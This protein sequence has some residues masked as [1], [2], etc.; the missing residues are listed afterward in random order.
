MNADFK[1]YWVWETLEKLIL[2]ESTIV[3]KTVKFLITVKP[4]DDIAGGVRESVT[5]P[6]ISKLRKG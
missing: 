5:E 4:E 6:V 1:Y 2:I 3:R